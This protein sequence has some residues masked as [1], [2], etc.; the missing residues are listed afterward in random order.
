V[1]DEQRT[2]MQQQINEILKMQ[3][4]EQQRMH[5]TEIT[6]KLRKLS[7]VFID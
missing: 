7:Q 2:Q 6:Q 3:T 5:L 4:H 1:Q